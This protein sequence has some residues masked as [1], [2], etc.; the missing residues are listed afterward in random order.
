MTVVTSQI[1]RAE[2]PKVKNVSGVKI[3]VGTAI[4]ASSSRLENETPYPENTI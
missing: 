3:S 2:P 1:A 4:P